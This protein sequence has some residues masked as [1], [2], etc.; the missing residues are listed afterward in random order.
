MLIGFSGMSHL[1]QTMR[2]AARLRGFETTVDDLEKSDLIFV[3][4]DVEDHDD[5]RAVDRHMSHAFEFDVSIVLMSQVP[6]QYT[7]GWYDRI[8]LDNWRLFYQVDTIIMNAALR[9]A[10]FPER[11]V[12]GCGNPQV[13]LPRPYREY[14]AAFDCPIVQMTYEGAEL[15]K[16]AVNY[17]LSKQVEATNELVQI[18]KEMNIDW[19]EMIPG[20]KLD[21]RIGAYLKPGDPRGGHLG[22]D[23]KT[24]EKLLEEVCT[25]PSSLAATAR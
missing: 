7:R 24:I 6:P 13:V 11:F 12:V 15:T 2:E 18:A 22:R 5:L 25:T 20:I 8:H 17:Y 9:R 21:A 14:L 3:T 19:D 16:L 4:Q 10:T 1:G 23:V